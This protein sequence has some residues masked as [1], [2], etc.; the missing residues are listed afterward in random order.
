MREE[1]VNCFLSISYKVKTLGLKLLD[2]SNSIR[3]LNNIFFKAIIRIFNVGCAGS[4]YCNLADL[5]TISEKLFGLFVLAVDG[6]PV[7]PIN[8]FPS[9]AILI[10]SVGEDAPSSEVEKMSLPGI[11][12]APGV[13]STCALISAALLLWSTPS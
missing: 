10:R 9:D 11:S 5:S 7:P 8:T 12:L 2:T 4:I 3:K 13:P 1:T 6:S